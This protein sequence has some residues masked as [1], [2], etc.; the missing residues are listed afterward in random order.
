MRVVIFSRFP[1]NILQ[2]RGG[3]ETATLG[4]VKGLAAHEEIDLHVVT[5]EKECSEHLIDEYLNI[6]IHRIPGPFL[7]MFIDILGGPGKKRLISYIESLAPDILHSQE[8]YGLVRPK[9]NFP[10]VFTLH[11]FDSLNLVAEKKWLWPL[12]SWIWKQVERYGLNSQTDV[13][14]ITPYVRKQIESL[15][16]TN[17]HDIE[18]AIS[19]DFFNIKRTEVS[20]R[21]FYAGWINPRKNLLTLIKAIKK[22]KTA[23]C[24]ITLHAAGEV[25]D[26]EYYQEVLSYIK[27]NNLENIVTLKG[28]LD[29]NEMKIELSQSSIFILPSYQE[30][31]PMAIAEAMA[32]GIPV[33][34]TR[35]CGMPYMIEEGETGYLVDPDDY[36]EMGICIEK[37]LKNN[38]L[39][40][41]MSNNCKQVAIDRYHP[42]SVANKTLDM[43]RKVI[44]G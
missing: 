27:V 17:I 43:Y 31:A 5:F 8:S 11:G 36:K 14:S 35:C 26:E 33:I 12:R 37:L 15:A 39:R 10:S 40:L 3:V 16:K 4:L 6:K 24:N 44:A 23:D 30:N 32:V 28:R 1:L 34:S 41:R 29:Q 22:L 42:A 13:V 19:D 9:R 21:I 20:G 38:P 18:N 7:P 25:S 2:P